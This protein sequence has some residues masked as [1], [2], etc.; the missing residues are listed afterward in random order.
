MSAARGVLMD[1]SIP[2]IGID[3]SD[4][5]TNTQAERNSDTVN[6]FPQ[7]TKVPIIAANDAATTAA[8]ELVAALSD[9][10]PNTSW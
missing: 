7:H 4:I 9:T 3:K 2:K 10:K 8:Q 5:V 1:L 6:F